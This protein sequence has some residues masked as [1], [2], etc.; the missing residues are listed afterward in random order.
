[1]SQK[2]LCILY[3]NTVL[4]VQCYIMS[5]IIAPGGLKGYCK[6]NLTINKL[7]YSYLILILIKLQMKPDQ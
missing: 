3:E 4:D 5:E 6:S 7:S 1:M 2:C